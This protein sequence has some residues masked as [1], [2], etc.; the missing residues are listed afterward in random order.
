MGEEKMKEILAFNKETE[1]KWRWIA[2]INGVE[3][4]IYVQKWRTPEP[5]P[6]KI[7]VKIGSPEDAFENKLKYTQ[8]EIEESPELK[9]EPIYEIVKKT[10]IMTETIRYNPII[11]R[12]DWELG[13]PYIPFELIPGEPN[14]LAIQVIWQ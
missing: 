8:K 5:I 9:H 12:N 14:K 10:D 4:K 11:E 13:E 3:F 6:D 7:L 1:M 2:D